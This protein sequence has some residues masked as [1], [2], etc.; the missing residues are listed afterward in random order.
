[1]SAITNAFKSMADVNTWLKLND[2]DDLTLADM[3]YIIPLRWTYFRDN[4]TFLLQNLQSKANSTLDPDLYNAQLIQFTN[5]I[6]YE[7]FNFSINPFANSLILNQYY[8][9]FDNIVIADIELTNEEQTIIN[10]ETARINI[11]SKN[12]FLNAA[13]NITIYR[14]LLTDQYGMG[15]MSYDTTVGRSAVA[16]QIQPSIVSTNY[17]L[18]LQYSLKTIDFIL[19]NLFAV[20]TALDPFA[21]ARANANNPD[22]NIGQYL[23]GKLV[24]LNYGESLATLALQYFGDP[25]KWIDIAIANGLKPP[26]IDETG[27]ALPLIANGSKN[28]INIAGTDSSGNSNI[29]RFYINQPVYLQSNTQLVVSQRIVTNIT[30]IP[31]SGDIIIQLN[32]AANLDLY[33]TTDAAN[34]RVFAPGT[35]NSSFYILIP[36]SDPLPNNRTE[37]IPWFL[38]TSA[39]DLQQTKVDLAIDVNGELNFSTDGDFILSYGLDN[40]IQAIKLKIITELGSLRYHPTFGLASVIGKTNADINA[41]INLLTQS[42]TD[43]ISNDSRF[44]RIE[45][46]SVDYL[47]S[48]SNPTSAAAIQVE[49][50]V[51]LAGGT[52]TVPIS[53]TVKT[54]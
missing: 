37:E 5:L 10:N 9:I 15:D 20:D 6:N 14:D 7:R 22:I 42:L 3:P 45:N 19:A 8:F 34:I 28:S 29:E 25:N 48:P 33:T 16:S 30:Q 35:T 12:D 39:P 41:L 24:K 40:A 43:Q 17:L 38:T 32:G 50:D 46:L 21:L 4:W 11:F 18:Q 49:L 1:M 47:V 27:V 23:S 31:I 53:F 26:Y 36:S 13:N 44:D 51:R 2:G 52:N 54:M